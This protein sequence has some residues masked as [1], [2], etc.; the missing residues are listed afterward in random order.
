MGPSFI[1]HS[2]LFFYTD[3]HHYSTPSSRQPRVNSTIV[4]SRNH[5]GSIDVKFSHSITGATL[6][7]GLVCVRLSIR[8]TNAY[9]GHTSHISDTR[10]KNVQPCTGRSW[11]WHQP[12][13]C[14][15]HFLRTTII[16]FHVTP[17]PDLW[18]GF[19]LY[20]FGNVNSYIGRFCPSS[21]KGGRVPVRSKGHISTWETHPDSIWKREI[22]NTWNLKGGQTFLPTS[23]Q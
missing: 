12:L 10:H 17:I 16:T 9:G 2:S 8:Q 20:R 7:E 5:L 23:L 22:F 3:P 15:A 14:P 13:K 4:H 6:R 18:T 19:G 1:P 11:Q 21:K